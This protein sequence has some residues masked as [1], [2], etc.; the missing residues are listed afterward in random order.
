MATQ[1]TVNTTLS[2]QSGTGNFVGTTSPTFVTPALGTPSSGTL[3]N[4]VSLS[5]TSGVSGIL[6]VA[7]GGTATSTA[8]TTGSV[9]FA[10]ASGVYS[11]DNSNL[12]WDNSTDRLSIGTTS[13]TTTLNVDGTISIF[14]GTRLVNSGI[15]TEGSG[16][17]IEMGGND[18]SDNRFG[19]SYDSSKEGGFF[20]MDSSTSA[21][22]YTWFGR[23]GG[24]SGT[25]GLIAQMTV[26][27]SFVLNPGSVLTTATDG[28]TYISTAGGTPTGVP[29][30]FGGT[31]P[32][33]WDS[34]NFTLYAY[35]SGWKNVVGAGSTSI[36][37]VGT[38]ATGTWNA[39]DVTTT[40]LVSS[41]DGI[42][43]G[44]LEVGFTGGTPT[45]DRVAVGDGAFYMDNPSGTPVLNWD[46]NDYIQFTRG[47][48]IL[49]FV[50][51]SATAM[52]LNS[53]GDL[54]VVG[55]LS[56]G[57][58][59]FK[60]DHPQDPLNKMLYHSFAESPDML[61]IYTGTVTLDGAGNADV[62]LPSYF[63]A[64]NKDFTYQLT[65][66]GQSA[67]LY[68]S[69]EVSGNQ[70]SIAG[71]SASQKVS[72]QVTGIRQDNFANCNRIPTEVDKV[73]G[74]IGNYIHPRCF[75]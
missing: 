44:G 33:V 47:T 61:N 12:F 46:G 24:V 27:G 13:S 28:F 75:E 39:G 7:N 6:P 36:T 31:A 64:L 2:G 21:S 53:S 5:L 60:I 10:G 51:S 69:Q 26:D 55:T 19:G 56:K 68:I 38:I 48:N 15:R 3:T 73:E 18:G 58:G 32:L 66:I 9:I 16:G 45:A 29:T 62:P 35:T 72:W 40:D 30:S 54:N 50:I 20:R 41:G 14:D 25:P 59:S 1:N 65:P 34:V 8:F 52:S 22:L 70:F 42:I 43:A 23:A 17:I 57:G 11:Q 67:S 4:C 74:E 49:D 63:E 71:G 37:T